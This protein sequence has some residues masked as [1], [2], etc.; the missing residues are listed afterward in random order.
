MTDTLESANTFEFPVVTPTKKVKEVKAFDRFKERHQSMK[1]K[2]QARI[3]AKFDALVTR[4]DSGEVCPSIYIGKDLH[5]GAILKEML[6]KEGFPIV[7]MPVNKPVFI[8]ITL[9]N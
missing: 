1:A 9:G 6:K 8:A 7:C 2:Q 4:L 5:V 3:Q